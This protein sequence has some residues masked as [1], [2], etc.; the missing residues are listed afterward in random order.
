MT[1]KML[2]PSIDMRLSSL[3]E[4]NRRRELDLEARNQ[5][6]KSRPTIT[7]SREFGCE[8]YPVAE[9]LRELL[10]KKSGETWVVMDKSLLEQVAKNHN[11]SE[12][13]LQKLGEKN[14]FLDEMLATFSPRWKSDK[15][16]FRLLCRHIVSLASAGNVIIVGRG[17]AFITQSLK[18]C[19]HFRMFASLK[20]KICSISRRLNITSEEAEKMI[21]AKQRQRDTFI[22]DFLDRDAHDLSVYNLVF[23]NDKNSPEKIARTILEYVLSA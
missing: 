18:N 1:E 19:H 17:S 3:L 23:N 6:K 10:E 16:H 9:R 13:I 7:L 12:D 14:L 15:D 11:L 22:R 20:Y 2:I 4:V 5:A 21:A 8:A